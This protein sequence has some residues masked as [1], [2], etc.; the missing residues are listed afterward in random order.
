TAGCLT[1]ITPSH[2]HEL[3]FPVPNRQN[4]FVAISSIS[5]TTQPLT[6][7]KMR[8]WVRRKLRSNKTERNGGAEPEPEPPYLPSVRSHALSTIT[9]HTARDGQAQSP[10]FRLPVELRRQILIA[11]FGGRTLH[12]DLRFDRPL[13][14]GKVPKSQDRHAG[15]ITYRHEGNSGPKKVWEWSGSVMQIATAAQERSR[16]TASLEHLDGC[17]PAAKRGCYLEGI[18]ILYSTNTFH[19]GTGPLL[20][21]ISR[22][23]R[24]Q[25]LESIN[26]LEIMIE[27]PKEK[28]SDPAAVLNLVP[29]TFPQLRH[30]RLHI[31]GHIWPQEGDQQVPPAQIRRRAEVT[32]RTLLVAVD[33]MYRRFACD[34]KDCEIAIYSTIFQPL[35][36]VARRGGAKMGGSM[37]MGSRCGA[38]WRPLPELPSA[39][40]NNTAI[41]SCSEERGY[42]VSDGKYLQLFI[43]TFGEGGLPSQVDDAYADI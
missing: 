29:A 34:L 24:P 21:H 22:L 16:K 10:F 2:H 4:L 15:I 18:A 37:G 27:I 39:P 17:K 19:I 23:V 6:T 35:I 36:N 7:E 40:N 1:R 20:E 11:A 12:M 25:R 3:L 8:K 13:L 28:Q 30:L 32:E 43:C 9:L 42:W 33:N 41:A 38:Y 14:K 31:G 5:L 26:S